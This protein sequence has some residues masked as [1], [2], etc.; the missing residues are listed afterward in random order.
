M[1]GRE[2]EWERL[3][4]HSTDLLSYYRNNFFLKHVHPTDP[5]L[6]IPIGNP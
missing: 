4:L 1:C 3:M 2:G 5:D 6:A